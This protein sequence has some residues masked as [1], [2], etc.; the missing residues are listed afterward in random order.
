MRRAAAA[1]EAPS[2]GVRELLGPLSSTSPGEAL[3]NSFVKPEMSTNTTVAS[4]VW[5]VASG[6]SARCRSSTRGTYGSRR[7]GLFARREVT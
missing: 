5:T 1:L 6:V 3:G 2:D 4:S 7:L